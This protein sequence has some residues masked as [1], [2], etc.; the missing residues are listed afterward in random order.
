MTLD[1]GYSEVTPSRRR[2]R[3][4]ALPVVLLLLWE[5]FSHSGLVNPQFLPPLEKI[6]ATAW[7]ELANGDLVFDLTVSLRRD[8][9]GF[10]VGSGLGGAV[11]ILLGI[12]SVAD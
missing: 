7:R 3:G 2:L 8:L 12:S 10:A 6:A 5:L 4:I 9:M 11:G 1:T